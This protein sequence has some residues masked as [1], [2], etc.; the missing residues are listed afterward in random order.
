M[1]K[2]PIVIK[3]RVTADKAVIELSLKNLRTVVADYNQFV[4]ELHRQD[5]REDYP[6][7]RIRN[8]KA[9]MK[10]LLQCLITG[11]D[12]AQEK[13]PEIVTM[14]IEDIL[15]N[16]ARNNAGLKSL[17]NTSTDAEGMQPSRRR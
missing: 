17:P 15:M 1:V 3:T 16:K 4:I 14:A 13:L 10:D 8:G 7:Y 6:T 2:K 5:P 9:F 11:R 12:T